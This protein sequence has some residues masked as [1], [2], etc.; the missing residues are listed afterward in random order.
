MGSASQLLRYNTAHTPGTHAFHRTYCWFCLLI[1]RLHIRIDVHLYHRLALG[2][3]ALLQL[4]P[5]GSQ[6]LLPGPHNRN[7]LSTMSTHPDRPIPLPTK[8]S[9]IRE[10][11]TTRNPVPARASVISSHVRVPWPTR[12]AFHL[13]VDLTTIDSLDL[14]HDLSGSDNALQSHDLCPPVLTMTCSAPYVPELVIVRTGWH[15][16]SPPRARYITRTFIALSC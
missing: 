1:Q 11:L 14:P 6:S 16:N 10:K 8:T 4:Q 13:R 2:L 9:S 7:G 12:S 15:L 3:P 5:N